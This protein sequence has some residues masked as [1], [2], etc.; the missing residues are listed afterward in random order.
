MIRK[1]INLFN[2][3]IYMYFGRLV[4]FQIRDYLLDIK[5]LPKADR[6]TLSSSSLYASL[7]DWPSLLGDFD[8]G[9]LKLLNGD[10]DLVL[11]FADPR[12]PSVALFVLSTLDVLEP[13]LPDPFLIN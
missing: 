3:L 2:A 6:G 8:L 1:G 10:L 7:P 13:L 5:A 4:R 9:H 11:D 12:P